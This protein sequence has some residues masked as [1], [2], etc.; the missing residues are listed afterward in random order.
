VYWQWLYVLAGVRVREIAAASR[1]VQRCKYVQSA[2]EK[3]GRVFSMRPVET[4]MGNGE[5]EMVEA[6]EALLIDMG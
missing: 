1:G 5:W 6:A 4:E 3:G 2:G